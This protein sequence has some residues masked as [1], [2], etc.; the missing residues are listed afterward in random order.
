MVAQDAPA[1][2]DHLRPIRVHT[3]LKGHDNHNRVTPCPGPPGGGGGGGG[4]GIL[5][6]MPLCGPY[7]VMQMV[8][9]T[10]CVNHQRWS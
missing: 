3:S 2:D 9:Q 7:S 6:P 10:A 1:A 4:G 8:M 5:L